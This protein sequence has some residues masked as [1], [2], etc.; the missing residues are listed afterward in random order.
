MVAVLLVAHSIGLCALLRPSPSQ[1]QAR[2]PDDAA[3]AA[4]VAAGPAAAAAIGAAGAMGPQPFT[5]RATRKED[6]ARDGSSLG[7]LFKYVFPCFRAFVLSCSRGPL[8][9]PEIVVAISLLSLPVVMS[10]VSATRYHS[11]LPLS[12][13][14][15]WSCQLYHSSLSLSSPSL[16]SCQLY[17]RPVRDL[18][19]RR[20]R[21][22]GRGHRR[23]HS[24]RR[25]RVR[26]L[27]LL[28]RRRRRGGANQHSRR[29]RRRRWQ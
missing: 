22:G 2:G 8:R 18:H 14:S 29:R 5:R 25:H 7:A 17:L 26:H 11:S 3:R 19:A 1:P 9:R 13:L 21:R 6:A 4:A 23:R 16:W 20:P 24:L 28:G 10:A 27:A 12:S 15:L